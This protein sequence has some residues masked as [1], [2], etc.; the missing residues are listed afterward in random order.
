MSCQTLLNLLTVLPTPT[1]PIVT[2]VVI[3]SI[4]LQNPT[5]SALGVMSDAKQ[6]ERPMAV[7]LFFLT[8]LVLM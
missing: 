1:T 6:L 5:T 3:Q 7:L 4:I 2:T 8:T